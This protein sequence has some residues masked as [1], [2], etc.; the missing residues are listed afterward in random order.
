MQ[1]AF[2]GNLEKSER[3]QSNRNSVFMSFVRIVFS[4]GKHAIR[5]LDFEFMSFKPNL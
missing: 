3:E 5:G 2:E 1:K 4:M